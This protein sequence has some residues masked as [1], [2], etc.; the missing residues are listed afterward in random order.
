[1][2]GVGDVVESV[3]SAVGK[4]VGAVGNVVESVGS[5]V[6]GVATKVVDEVGNVVATITESV[7]GFIDKVKNAVKS[8]IDSFKRIILEKLLQIK[9]KLKIIISYINKILTLIEHLHTLIKIYYYT[10]KGEIHKA[11]VYV[12]Q[13]V[14][15]KLAQKVKEVLAY[16]NEKITEV[17]KFINDIRSIIYNEISRIDA[18]L[19]VFQL[20]FEDMADALDVKFIRSIGYGIRKFRKDVLGKIRESVEDAE[21]ELKNLIYVATDPF[22]ELYKTFLITERE[23][24]RF[25]ILFARLMLDSANNEIFSGKRKT[26]SIAVPII[27]S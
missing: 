27:S 13:E 1:M 23:Y 24:E 12:L 21:R 10:V 17:Y 22:V 26:L 16:I 5:T 7:T 2:G 3:G 4:V 9:N 19:S 8:V 15:K 25:R 14:D 11:I 20:I 18:R 6:G